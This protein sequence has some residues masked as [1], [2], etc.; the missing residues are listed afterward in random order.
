MPTINNLQI[1]GLNYYH[2]NI[3]ILK[4]IF[5]QREE[6]RFA[7]C[8]YYLLLNAISKYLYPFKIFFRRLLLRK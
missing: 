8:V 3:L 1:Y 6:I 2:K 7:L 5:L 4:Q